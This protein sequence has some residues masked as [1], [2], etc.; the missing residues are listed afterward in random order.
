METAICEA[1]EGCITWNLM[2]VM[3]NDITTCDAD[4]IVCLSV[5]T[6]DQDKWK[7]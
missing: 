6:V 2:A 5:Q 7:I 3:M 1:D 4:T